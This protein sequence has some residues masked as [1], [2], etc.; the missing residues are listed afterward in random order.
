[1]LPIHILFYFVLAL[2]AEFSVPTRDKITFIYSL[3][4]P[5][6]NSLPQH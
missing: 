4:A 1:M 6:N 3:Y 2:K 5:L